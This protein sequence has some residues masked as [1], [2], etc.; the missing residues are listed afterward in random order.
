MEQGISRNEILNELS[1]SSHGKYAEYVPTISLAAAKDPEF[2]AHL[3]AYDAING[4]VKDSKIAVPVISLLPAYPGELIENSLAHLMLLPPREMLKAFTFSGEIGIG[5]SRRKKLRNTIRRFLLH[6]EQDQRKWSSMVVR[7]RQAVTDLY[8]ETRCAMPKWA[9]EI[10][11][12]SQYVPGSIFHD[13]KN[14]EY[15]NSSQAAATIQKWRLSPLI[16][17]S[18]LG[19]AKSIKDDSAVVQ[20]TLSQMSDTE[21]VTKV[22]ALEKSG[23]L[24]DKSTK[25]VL[26]KKLAKATTTKKATLKTSVAAE[27][28]EDESLKTML[29]ELQERQIASQQAAGRGID[30]SWLVISDKSG[31]QAESIDL[32]K[33]IASVITRFV[34]GRV[35]LA[36]CDTGCYGKEVTGE[37]LE[38]IKSWSKFVMAN[39]G[40]SYGVGLEW[41]ISKKFE[42]DGVVIVGDGA[43][44]NPPAYAYTHRAYEQSAGKRI[45]TYIFLT[46][47]DS[48]GAFQRSMKQIGSPL[49]EF[50]LTH[51]KVDYY[52]LPNLVQ[53]MS[54]NRFGVIE[55]IMACP[56]LTLDQV[57]PPLAVTAR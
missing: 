27:E 36:F 44:N 48:G 8:A 10:L 43:E 25:E 54:A 9:S 3:I 26:R 46:K 14:L 7:H 35:W 33:Q 39:G 34:S 47:G 51:G 53:Q 40:T 20:A 57:L 22:K 13:V 4:Q 41:A 52:S 29:K 17:Q 37:S 24:S 42:L 19:R 12:K 50:D 2:V 6:K 28:V 56:L 21:V 55:K 16:A 23:A 11:F 15:M 38:V 5:I 31:S 30:G 18:A 45:P 49:T 32:G 1:R